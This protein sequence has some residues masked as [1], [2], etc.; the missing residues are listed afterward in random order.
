MKKLIGILLALYLLTFLF[1]ADHGDFPDIYVD[2]SV[3][4]GGVGSNADP[5]SDFSEINWTTGGDNSIFDWYAGAEDASATINLQRGQEWREEFL[6]GAVEGSATY[7]II[8]RPYGEGAAPIINGSNVTT[9]WEA[10]SAWVTAFTATLNVDSAKEYDK[11]FRNVIANGSLSYAGTQVGLN[12]LRVTWTGHSSTA[13]QIDGASI[14][15]QNANPEDYEVAPTRITFDTG[16]VFATLPA[17]GTKVSDAIT[18]ALDASDDHLIHYFMGTGNV[19]HKVVASGY[20]GAYTWYDSP[21]EDD[22]TMVEDISGYDTKAGD[23]YGVSK[24]E[25]LVGTANVWKKTGITA[26]PYIV[27][28]DGTIGIYQTAKGNLASA[29]DWFWDDAD[30]ILYV[31]SATD[32]DSAW[33]EVEVGTRNHCIYLNDTDYMTIEDIK[34]C[35]NKTSCFRT[36]DA[37]NVIFRDS[38]IDSIG[39]FGILSVDSTDM[40]FQNLHI[41]NVTVEE[42]VYLDASKENGSGNIIV[43]YCNIHDF[44]ENGIYVPADVSNGH[45]DITLRYNRIIDSVSTWNTDSISAGGGGNGNGIQ[46]GNL[47]G[48]DI[49]YNYLS[50]TDWRGIQL[51]TSSSNVNIYNNVIYGSVDYVCLSI[52]GDV[53]NIKNNIIQTDSDS[54]PIMKILTGATN[55]TISNNRYY[56]TGNGTD[57]FHWLGTDY[58]YGNFANWVTASSDANSATGDPLFVDAANNDFRLLMASPCINKGTDVG[59]TRDYRGRSIRHAPDIGAY[60]DPTNVLFLTRLFKYIKERK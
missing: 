28:F 13:G 18:F 44:A 49:Y 41:H 52:G 46:G 29:R 54:K 8:V 9:G 19:A 11:N 42:A 37:T 59:L 12:N 2:E 6:P 7:P 50:N 25:V 1:G 3:A 16:N 57:A 51:A 31:Y 34:L 35:G 55:V 5:Y 27:I 21:S 30:D 23:C 24:I 47:D 56:T 53:L 15:L 58:T 36:V 17:A 39:R 22:D 48:L 10:D 38:E 40:L 4:P 20:D 32:P 45:Y 14:G 43:E 60:E 33:S 26:Q